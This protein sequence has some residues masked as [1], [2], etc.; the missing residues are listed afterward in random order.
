PPLATYVQIGNSYT[1]TVTQGY[2]AENTAVWIDWNN[3]GI[4]Q[5]SER[6]LNTTGTAGTQYGTASTSVTIPADAAI[7]TPLRMRVFSDFY[8]SP[9]LAA[10]NNPLYGQ[11]EDFT[12]I[13]Q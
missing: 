2:N 10:C 5:S 12:V 4:F 8:G 3:D 13:V 6:V 7:C 11:V 1:L 9:P